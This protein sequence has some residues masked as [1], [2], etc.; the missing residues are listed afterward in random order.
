VLANI[1]TL[2]VSLHR[3]TV[4]CPTVPNFPLQRDGGKGKDR[5][6][7]REWEI[8]VFS[9]LWSIFGRELPPGVE[10]QLSGTNNTQTQRQI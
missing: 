1:S 5:D 4:I 6:K 8:S 7:V 9:I 3:H 10:E 2:S